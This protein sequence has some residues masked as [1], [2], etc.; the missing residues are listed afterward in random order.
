MGTNNYNEETEKTMQL[1]DS[2][3]KAE[4]S[5]YFS[6]RLEAR[7]QKLEEQKSFPMEWK[8]TMKYALFIM[9]IALNVIASY[10]YLKGDS[11]SSSGKRKSMIEE[12]SSMYFSDN[13]SSNTTNIK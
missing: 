13:I 11:I 9:I 7:I 5:A 1:L 3:E 2:L 8:L 12:V 10:S 4:S 6:T